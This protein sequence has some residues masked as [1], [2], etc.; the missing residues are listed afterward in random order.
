MVKTKQKMADEIR[1]SIVAPLRSN[2]PSQPNMFRP[3]QAC[4]DKHHALEMQASEN[5]KL[6]RC[7]SDQIDRPMYQI[8]VRENDGEITPIWIRLTLKTVNFMES[9][10]PASRN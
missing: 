10:A 1:H 3:N 5:V 7:E 6:S 9:V 4:Q 8:T 2:N